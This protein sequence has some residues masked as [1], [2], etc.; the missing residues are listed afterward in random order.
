MNKA[1]EGSALKLLGVAQKMDALGA[2]KAAVERV[3]K[4]LPE[5][6]D[7]VAGYVPGAPGKVF[8]DGGPIS[9]KRRSFLPFGEKYFVVG[10][11]SATPVLEG[12]ELAASKRL[13]Y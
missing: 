13:Y 8:F 3:E 2:A 11:W 6:R 5:G 10:R 1:A 9:V 12:A 7:P 4:K